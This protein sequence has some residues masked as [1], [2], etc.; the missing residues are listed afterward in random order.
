MHESPQ[1]AAQDRKMVSELGTNREQVKN[2]ERARRGAAYPSVTRAKRRVQLGPTATTRSSQHVCAV[3]YIDVRGVW[4]AARER[5]PSSPEFKEYKTAQSS[6]SVSSSYARPARRRP[7]GP[8]C[9]RCCRGQPSETL[10]APS[11]DLLRYFPY[12]QILSSSIPPKTRI[13]GVG[14]GFPVSPDF[15]LEYLYTIRPHGCVGKLSAVPHGR[16]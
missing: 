9:Q 4:K 14:I 3:T 6:R 10:T 1:P 5:T 12:K 11:N 7:A 13:T 8:V 16:T 15:H 2:L